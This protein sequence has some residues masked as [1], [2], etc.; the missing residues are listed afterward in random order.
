MLIVVDADTGDVVRLD[1]SARRHLW[2]VLSTVRK[3]AGGR[4]PSEL[5]DLERLADAARPG[6]ARRGPATEV[7]VPLIALHDRRMYL[8]P[9]EAA[10]MLRRSERTIR[11]RCADGRLAAF[12]EG[13][14]WRIPRAELDRLAN[15]KEII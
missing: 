10:T 11:Q 14:A 12:R 2:L 9:A 5:L 4:L 13:R 15:T 3:A 7:D 1:E 8:T 6:E